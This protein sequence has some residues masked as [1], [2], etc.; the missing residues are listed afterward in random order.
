M[1]SCKKFLKDKADYIIFYTHVDLDMFIVPD[2]IE[3]EELEEKFPLND[4]YSGRKYKSIPLTHNR[5]LNQDVLFLDADSYVFDN[6]F[7]YIFN[8]LETKS[9]LICGNMNDDDASWFKGVSASWFKGVSK[10]DDFNLKQKAQIAGY[11]VCNLHLNSG[12]IGRANNEDGHQFANTFEELLAKNPIKIFENNNYFNDEI[13]LSLAYQLCTKGKDIGTMKLEQG[14]YV[15][16]VKASLSDTDTGWP[17][18]YKHQSKKEHKNVAII[19]FVQFK[20]F[21]FYMNL[22]RNAV[23]YKY[24]NRTLTK[25]INH[26]SKN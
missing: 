10:E 26:F 22:V 8:L 11:D 16:T 12:I 17:N 13:Y 3:L 15:T 4:R 2:W 14:T 5:C 1:I 20:K 9:I 6:R 18:V 25:L 24:H 7:D 19:H 21:P 23:P